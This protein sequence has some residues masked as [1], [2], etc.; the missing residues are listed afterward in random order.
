MRN[1]CVPSS[2]VNV[3]LR[4]QIFIESVIWYMLCPIYD[5]FIVQGILKILDKDS[6]NN[7]M[8]CHAQDLHPYLQG[9]WHLEVKA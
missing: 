2:K 4:G 7:M 1:I 3:T 6:H 8:I 5:F 9:Q